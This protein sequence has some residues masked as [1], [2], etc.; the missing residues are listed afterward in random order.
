MRTQLSPKL[1]A[2]ILLCIGS[3]QGIAISQ[4]ANA[5]PPPKDPN[6]FVPGFGEL[7]DGIQLRHAKLWFAGVNAN[8]AL[9]G[10]LVDEITEDFDDVMVY[11]PTYK[12]ESIVETTQLLLAEPLQ[13]LFNAVVNQDRKQFERAFDSLSQACNACHAQIGI[14]FVVIQRPT[15][16]PLTNQQY[17]PP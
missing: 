15:A 10:F 4:L 5:Q 8:W 16:P 17:S 7:M 1:V 12:R 2:L 13:N 11:R 6:N 9:A 3:I 14:P